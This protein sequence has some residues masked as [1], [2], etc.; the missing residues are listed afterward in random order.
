M[1]NRFIQFA[2]AVAI[3][4]TLLSVVI[5]GINAFVPHLDFDEE[6]ERCWQK[7]RTE[8][9]ELSAGGESLAE[10]DAR[11]NEEL[12]KQEECLD[13]VREQEKTFAQNAFM[14]A[15]AVGVIGVAVGVTVLAQAVPLAANGVA[16]GGLLTI[17]FGMTRGL[18]FIDQ[19][20]AFVVALLAFALLLWVAWRLARGSRKSGHRSP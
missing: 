13:A 11:I 5:L 15:V 14:I 1:Q 17:L 12:A 7:F 20:L 10:E 8:P 9:W 6:R 16:F 2:F 18:P 3:A 19:R 4:A